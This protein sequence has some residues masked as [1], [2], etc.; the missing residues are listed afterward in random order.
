MLDTSKFYVISVISN[1]VRYQSRW[2]LYKKFKTH[3]AELGGTLITVE[4][5]FGRREFQVTE[6]GNPHHVQVRTNHELWHKENL[7]NLGM[8]RLSDIDPQWQ[9]MAWV[10]ADITFQRPDALKETAQQL[11]HY[12]VVQMFSH[13]VD[14]GPRMENIQQ[15]VGFCYMYHQNQCYPPQTNGHGGY[16]AAAHMG[17]TFWHPGYAWAARR[18]A[19]DKIQLMDFGILGAGDHHMA[20]G[21]IGEARRSVPGHISQ[22]YLKAVMEWEKQALYAIRKNIGYVP[23]LITHHWHGNKKQRKYIERW[24]VITRNQFDPARDLSRDSFGLYRLNM[25][26]GERSIRLRD[27]IR[28]YFRQRNEDSIDFDMDYN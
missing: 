5:A 6:A 8:Y 22:G 26:H 16:Y 2:N 4:Q 19:L 25:C 24:Q 7:I 13:V 14:L 21:L 17:M 18:E 15:N 23:G 28:M 1:P 10:D 27:E 20:L 9:Y 11:Q 12:D 3:I